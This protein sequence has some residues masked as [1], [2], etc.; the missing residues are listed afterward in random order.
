MEGRTV[1]LGR[2]LVK[3]LTYGQA[4]AE[5]AGVTLESTFVVAQI[6]KALPSLEARGLLGC[7]ELPLMRCLRRVI[8]GNTPADTP[9]DVDFDRPFRDDSK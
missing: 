7:D 6:A 2:L 1:R 8:T 9:A 5:L 4:G 3:G